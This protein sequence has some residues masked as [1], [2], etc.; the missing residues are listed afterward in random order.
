MN[1]PETHG[2]PL[3]T[4]TIVTG[5]AVNPWAAASL[6][7]ATIRRLFRAAS[8][9]PKG[10][11]LNGSAS[12]SA[13][14][15]AEAVATIPQPQRQ[16]QTIVGVDITG[17][18][19]R[20][21]QVQDHL[22]AT[23]YAALQQAF[24]DAGVKWPAREW[25]DDR[26][27]GVLLILPPDAAHRVI[28]PLVPYL[29]AGLRRHNKLSSAA[30]Q[31]MLRMAV[32]SGYIH[33]DEHGLSGEAIVQMCRLLDAPA[34]KDAVRARRAPLGVV[35]SQYIYEAVVRNGL[36]LI[37][38]DTYRRIPVVNKETRTEAWLH[39]PSRAE[40]LFWPALDGTPDIDTGGG[41]TV[42]R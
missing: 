16:Y 15:A 21:E 27:D 12:V 36:G 18:G 20:E 32:H 39:L 8:G 23:M 34:F 9:N 3:G 25:R 33:Q 35:V 31:I 4:D 22:R 37:D 7:T 41:R 1:S 6:P 17:F 2:Y 28:D 38:P 29:H 42:V 30:A 13:N 5:R 40:A 26:G 14:D 11:T 24:A 19:G 10:S